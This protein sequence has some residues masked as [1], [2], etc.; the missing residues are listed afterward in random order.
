MPKNIFLYQ[1]GEP[2]EDLAEEPEA[3]QKKKESGPGDPGLPCAAEKNRGPEHIE[4]DSDHKHTTPREN[5][6]SAFPGHGVGILLDMDSPAFL[7]G[8]HMMQV[9][10]IPPSRVRQSGC[11]FFEFVQMHILLGERN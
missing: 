10:Y 4:C 8:T 7:A 5:L 11:G 1:A 6:E 2:D 3:G 9:Q